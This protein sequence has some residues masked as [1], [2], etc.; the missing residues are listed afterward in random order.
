MTITIREYIDSDLPRALAMNNAA[1]PAVNELDADSFAQLIVDCDRTWVVD[2]DDSTSLGGLLVTVRPGSAYG[3]ANYAWLDERYDDF[4]YVD[5]III[6]PSHKRLG[7][8]SKLYAT[9]EL[10]A[11]EQ[12]AA[13]L[14]C[15]VNIEPPNPQSLAFHAERGWVPIED[16]VFGEG[17]AVRYLQKPLR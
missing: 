8:G 2:D 17:K 5:R 12:Q 6:A 14:L 9:L 4:C 1:L 16:R 7:L 11:A 15:E 13:R 10:H 3:S